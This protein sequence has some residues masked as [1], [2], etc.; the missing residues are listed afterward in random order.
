MDF[1]FALDGRERQRVRARVRIARSPLGRLLSAVAASGGR[2]L[3]TAK[4]WKMVSLSFASWNQTAAWLRRLEG[5]R[6]AA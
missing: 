6:G 3:L 1:Q 4:E 2:K 5:L